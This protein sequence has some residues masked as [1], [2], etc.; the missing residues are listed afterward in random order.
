MAMIVRD[1]FRL[2]WM[3]TEIAPHRLDV[4]AFATARGALSGTTRLQEFVRLSAE[5]TGA[6]PDAMVQWEARGE[7]RSGATGSAEP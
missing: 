5:T 4:T 6:R 2:D 3:K 1:G 7:E